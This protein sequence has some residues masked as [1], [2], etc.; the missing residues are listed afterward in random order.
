[1]KL[2]AGSSQFEGIAQDL[3][4]QGRLVVRLD[5]GLLRAFEVGEVTLLR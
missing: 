1:M 2:T 5:S 3:D 4:E